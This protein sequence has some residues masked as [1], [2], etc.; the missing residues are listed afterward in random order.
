MGRV[1]VFRPDGSE[2]I[3][4][5]TA[6]KVA[7]NEHIGILRDVSTR[8]KVLS[9]LRRLAAVV[10]CSSDSFVG[11]STDG[12]ITDWNGGAERMYGYTR[13]EVLGKPMTLLMLPERTDEALDIFR[14]VLQGDD[15]RNRETVLIR[16][17]GTLIDVAVTTSATKDADGKVTGISTIAHDVS[18]RKHLERHVLEIADHERQRIGQDLHDDLGQELTGIG[19]MVSTLAASLA[20][21]GNPEAQLA[22]NIQARIKT[23]AEHVRNISSGLI[24]VSIDAGGLPAALQS[25]ADNVTEQGAC[26]CTFACTTPNVLQD[27]V[28]A[29]ELFRIAQEAVNNAVKHARANHIRIELTASANLIVLRISDNG[30]GMRLPDAH[31]RGLGLRIMRYRAELV[32]AQLKFED[33]P[34]GGLLI[35][36]TVR[37]APPA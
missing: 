6:L 37:A 15:I 1:Q 16:K 36:C 31:G 17:D 9:S 5:Y 2:G 24:P 33:A 18:D 32:A 20:Q 22:S 11:L 26:A 10:A 3:I 8:E 7:P 13:D 30:L 21:R 19:R 35:T 34:Q 25:L 4:E 12:L 27:N 29:N 14:R 28:T 23:A